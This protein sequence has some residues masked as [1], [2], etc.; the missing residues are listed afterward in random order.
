[1][2]EIDPWD[3]VDDVDYEATMSQFGI[4]PMGDLARRL[5]DSKLVRRG[6]VFGHRDLDTVLDARDRGDE[7]A[8]MT[9][10]M[11]SGPF[12]FGHKS[13]VEHLLLYQ[14]LGA[15]VTLCAA[16]VEAY[17]TR[18]LSLAEARELVVSEY[19]TNYVALGLDLEATDFYFQSAAGNDHHARSKLFARHLTQ[20]QFEATYG[21]AD[22]GKTVSALTQ[23]ADMVRPQAERGRPVPT[24]IPVGIDQDPHVRLARD[25]VPR[26][27][28][29]EFAKPASTY[30]RFMRG[31]QGGKMSSSDPE[32]H[33]ALTDSVAE[34]KRK[35]D[36]AKT[37]GRTS[38]AEHREK[39]GD[40]GEDMV[41]ELLAFH[42]VEDDAELARIRESY[43]AGDLLSGEL[44]E[45][46]K[47][48][49][50]EVLCAHQKRREEVADEVQRYVDEH[51]PTA[52]I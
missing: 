22:P 42:L 27:R 47:T 32:S 3:A 50:E 39:G 46:A 44:K 51:V 10:I 15:S 37:G 20:N 38:V 40:V 29:E 4:E 11:P 30:H 28:E 16:D 23:Y 48:R 14:E 2:P 8:V 26:Y 34:A 1:M 12:H 18:G 33:V 24:V 36:G 21:D 17:T 25:V 52:R 45:L 31:L 5:P 43:E 19:L 6:I 49:V 35:I 41:F 13:V 7:F 9:G